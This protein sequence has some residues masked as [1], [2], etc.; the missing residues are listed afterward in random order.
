MIRTRFK[1]VLLVA[2]EVF[3]EHLLTDYKHVKHISA[4]SSVFPSIFQFN[5]DLII[6]DHDF[7]GSEMIKT[8]RRI[9]VNKFYN[10]IK[11]NCYKNAPNEKTDSLL[12]VLGVDQFIYKEDLTKNLKSKAEVKNTHSIFDTSI[13]KWMGGVAN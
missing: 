2:P 13:L 5:P 1:K 12:K 7:M 6:F 10:K 9:Q 11:I 8:L 4:V 3:P